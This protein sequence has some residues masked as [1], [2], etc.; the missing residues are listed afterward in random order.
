[1]NPTWLDWARRL[2]AIAQGGLA[3]SPSQYDLERYN[4]VF[5]ALRIYR[6]SRICQNGAWIA[7]VLIGAGGRTPGAKESAPADRIASQPLRVHQP[8]NRKSTAL[9]SFAII[10]RKSKGP[11][12]GT[13]RQ[14]DVDQGEPG[15]LYWPSRDEYSHEA[16]L[17][18]FFACARF[19]CGPFNRRLVAC[20]RTLPN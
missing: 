7:C 4:G 3:F 1:M 13:A 5:D 12:H 8:R 2:Q 6:D 10:G 18:G 17:T 9:P 20:S 16:V 14:P 11:I 15:A 19:P